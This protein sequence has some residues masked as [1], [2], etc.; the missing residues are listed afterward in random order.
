[1]GTSR[2]RTLFVSLLTLASPSLAAT[3]NVPPRVAV[4]GAPLELGAKTSPGSLVLAASG[5]GRELFLFDTETSTLTRY[6]ETGERRREE[7]VLRGVAGAPFRPKAPRLAVAGEV[8]AVAGFDGMALF[9]DTGELLVATRTLPLVS[10]LAAAGGGQWL[11]GLHQ[12]GVRL[13]GTDTAGLGEE[14]PRLVWVD[15]DLE[16]RRTGLLRER[17]GSAALGAAR[18]LRVAFDGERVYAA[19]LANYRIHELDSGLRLRHTWEVPTLLFE[20]AETDAAEPSSAPP[21]AVRNYLETLPEELVSRPEDDGKQVYEAFSHRDVVRAMAWD[22]RARRLVL[23]IAPGIVAD[24]A[25]LDLLDPVTGIL[26]RGL[27][28][29]PSGEEASPLVSQ[30]VVGRR[31][32]WFRN[33]EG[34]ST[35]YR[36]DRRSFDTFRN[37]V[38]PTPA[39]AAE[40]AE[41]EDGLATG[42]GAPASRGTFRPDARLSLDFTYG[43]VPLR[44][45]FEVLAGLLVQGRSDL[46]PALDATFSGTF[47][48]AP[49][50]VILDTL[51]RPAGCQWASEAILLS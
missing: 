16:L 34:R 30:L 26:T 42:D 18:A 15:D 19:E 41:A 40:E 12:L 35:T 8:V 46:D 4:E 31:F 27:L 33:H 49:A 11:L 45:I 6:L 43:E 29:H 10:S 1:M 14:E 22:S 3:A 50:E 17:A 48:E 23:F 39:T 5:D 28:A 7:V 36:V 51:C 9:R 20:S 38:D 44:D 47:E 25:A 37:V 2:W 32:L 21:K 24:E 13:P